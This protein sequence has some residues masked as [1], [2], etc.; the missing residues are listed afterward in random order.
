M[1]T[2]LASAADQMIFRIV[3]IEVYPENLDDYVAAVKTFGAES[4][5]KEP[6][7]ICFFPMQEKERPT[8]IRIVQIFRDEAAYKAHIETPHFKAYKDVS[9]HWVKSVNLEPVQPLDPEHTSLIFRKDNPAKK[10]ETVYQFSVK[11]RKGEDVSLAEYKGKVL[12]IVN[13]ATRCGFTPQYEGLEW[14][15]EQHK[16]KGFELLD[17]PCNQFG[18]Q[19]PGSE[20]E[21]HTFCVVNYKTAF[22]QFAKIDVNGENASPLFRFLAENTKFEGFPQDGKLAPLLEKMLRE[23]DPDY[24]KKPDVKWNFTKF[25]IGRDGKIVRRF[26]PTAPLSDIEAEVEKALRLP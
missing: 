17:F 24:A 19:A 6:G 7:V 1:A 10:A 23:A 25:L 20:D 11:G 13:T 8:Q 5:A 26:E 21:I 2:I 14:L 9:Y 16:D 22:P 3:E 12:L 15:Y 4:V 18:Q